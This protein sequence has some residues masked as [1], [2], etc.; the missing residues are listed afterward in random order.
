M[1]G[2]TLRRNRLNG[3]HGLLRVTR[4]SAGSRRRNGDVPVVVVLCSP[5]SDRREIRY[6]QLYVRRIRLLSRSSRSLHYKIIRVAYTLGFVILFNW[7]CVAMRG[8]VSLHDG[9]LHDGSLHGGVLCVPR[10]TREKRKR[11]KRSGGDIFPHVPPR[12]LQREL[13]RE[14]P[15]R[16]ESTEKR[17]RVKRFVKLKHTVSCLSCL[18]SASRVEFSSLC[19][20][21]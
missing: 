21:S 5:Y 4:T 8:D 18:G 3:L 14:G 15:R 13:R 7:C 6:P 16:Q 19:R 20:S 1:T 17:L 2:G 11:G 12:Q 9:S 10:S